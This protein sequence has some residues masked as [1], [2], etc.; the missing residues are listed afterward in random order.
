[1]TM[2]ASKIS[3]GIFFL[4][5]TVKRIHRWIVYLVLL[6]TVVI[7]IVYLFVSLMQ[8]EPVSLYWDESQDGWCIDAKTIA[9]LMY[10]YSAFA[11]MCDS[12]FALLPIF[13]I[14]GL[15]MDR[16]TKIALVPVLGMGCV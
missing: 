8:C 6:T 12:A 7:G 15:Q 9:A 16:Q 3:I 4:R 2:V 14:R 1:M 11:L 13:M 5:L 10:P